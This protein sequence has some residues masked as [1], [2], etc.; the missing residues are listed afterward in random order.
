MAVLVWSEA[1]RNPEL[2]S[3]F[4]A[5]LDELRGD[6]AQVIRAHQS[7]GTLPRDPDPE[8]L[9]RLLLMVVPGFILQL[10]LAGEDAVEGIPEAAGH[11]GS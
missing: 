8:A 3:R 5:L 9:A 1:L 7:R 6:L 2:A 11:L 10:A 4:T